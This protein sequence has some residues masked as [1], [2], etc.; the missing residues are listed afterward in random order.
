[1]SDEPIDAAAAKMREAGQ[2]DAAI[3]QFSSA[4]ER[5]RSGVATLIPSSELEPAP[6]VPAAR[7]AA[8][9]RPRD[10]CSSASP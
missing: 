3:R 5:V 8:R 10:R 6:D 9:C 2:S 7:R 4:L 1:M